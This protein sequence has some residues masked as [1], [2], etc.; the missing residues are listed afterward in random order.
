MYNFDFN[1]FFDHVLLTEFI[2]KN[3]LTNANSVRIAFLCYY[4]NHVS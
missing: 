3:V 4:V 2:K 1:L